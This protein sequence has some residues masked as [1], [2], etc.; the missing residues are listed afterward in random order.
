MSNEELIKKFKS[1]KLNNQMEI[2]SEEDNLLKYKMANDQESVNRC[3]ERL[4]YLNSIKRNLEVK[5]QE[6]EDGPENMLKPI[7]FSADLVNPDFE[8]L[9]IDEGTATITYTATQEA[10]IRDGVKDIHIKKEQTV[11]QTLEVSGGEVIRQ[12]VNETSSTHKDIKNDKIEIKSK[13]LK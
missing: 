6:L 3:R 2:N 7:P 8:N 10:S 4:N 5:I 11:K 12:T 9:P 1:E 13:L